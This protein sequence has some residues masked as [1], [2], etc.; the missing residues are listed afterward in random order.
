MYLISL[1]NINLNINEWNIMES[2]KKQIGGN[3]YKN[4]KIQPVEFIV[5]CGMNFLQGCIVKRLCR[6]DME[7]GKGIEDLRKILHETD[8]MIDFQQWSITVVSSVQ[9]KQLATFLA[10]NSFT[11]FQR[12]QLNIFINTLINE[13]D[14]RS[15]YYP[16]KELENFK[17]NIA[18]EIKRLHAQS[19]NDS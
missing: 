9:Y 14:N 12:N 3:H 1:K 13:N 7:G 15:T 4:F 17:N 18:E 2:L 5:N 6:Y 16:I 19:E 10:V 8:L 11:S